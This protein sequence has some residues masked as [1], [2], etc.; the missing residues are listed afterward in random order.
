[1]DLPEELMEELVELLE[2]L[3]VLLQ[4]QQQVE[5]GILEV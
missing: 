2:F 1:M 5:L 4:I 3:P